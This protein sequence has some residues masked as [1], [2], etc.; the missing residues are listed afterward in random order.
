MSFDAPF[1]VGQMTGSGRE[2]GQAAHG[3]KKRGRR[4]R[5]AVLGTVVVLVG[6]LTSGAGTISLGTD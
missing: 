5:P 6:A 4:G 3:D 1:S 2:T